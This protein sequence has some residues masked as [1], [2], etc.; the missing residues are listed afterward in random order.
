MAPPAS[1]GFADAM[2]RPIRS[3]RF[4]KTI[5]RPE[6]APPL[7]PA[8]AFAGRPK[9]LNA[10]NPQTFDEMT[11]LLDHVRADDGV[12][13]LV[14]TGSGEKAFVA[15]ADIKV[16][17]SMNPLQGRLFSEKGQQVFSRLEHLPIPVIACVNGFALGGGL[18]AAL[19]CDFIYAS[20]HARFGFP[21]VTLG[22]LPGFGGTQRLARLIGRARAKELCMSGE[23]STPA[24][25]WK[26]GWWPRCS[27]RRSSSRKP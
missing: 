21:E 10:L 25:R 22:L 15:G 23:M 7:R 8:V 17:P 11:A 20:E 1:Q 24:E 4:L 13:V 19:G 18:E 14:L 3:A 6:Q 2:T 9:A 16:F 26:S 5:T 27:R 12:R